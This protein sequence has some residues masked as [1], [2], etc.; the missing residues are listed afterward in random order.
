MLAL[1]LL[2]SSTTAYAEVQPRYTVCDPQTTYYLAPTTGATITMYSQ[3]RWSGSLY[4]FEGKSM[5]ASR[6]LWGSDK[7]IYMFNESTGT[8][9]FVGT[10]QLNSESDYISKYHWQ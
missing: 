10:I 1:S 5:T 9:R 8:V 6:G 2:L 3:L 7:N 4:T